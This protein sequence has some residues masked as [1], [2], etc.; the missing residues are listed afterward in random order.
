MNGVNAGDVLH[1]TLAVPHI[2]LARFACN[3]EVSRGS[4]NG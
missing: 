3:V 2:Q 1:A 4:E